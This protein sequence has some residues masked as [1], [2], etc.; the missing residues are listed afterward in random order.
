MT[1]SHTPK[2]PAIPN[3]ETQTALPGCYPILGLV[4][5]V[6]DTA[7]ESVGLDLGRKRVWDFYCWLV[8]IP[9]GR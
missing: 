6:R 5:Q 4:N 8:E 7:Y 1:D 9:D 3:A 2:L